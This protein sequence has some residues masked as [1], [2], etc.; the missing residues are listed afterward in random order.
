MVDF[1]M[2]AIIGWGP[3]WT[4]RGWARCGGQLLSIS[5][6]TA[7]YSLIG[8]IYGGDGRVTF[9]LPDLR[10]RA[11]IGYGQSPGTSLY[12]IGAWMGTEDRTLTQLELPSHTHIA[13]T[14]QMSVS[15]EASESV[16]GNTNVPGPNKI[17]AKAITPADGPLPKGDANIYTD[18]TN[19]D[20]TILAGAVSGRIN[21]SMTGGNQSFSILQPVSVINFVICM[22]GI[23]PSRE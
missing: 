15:I 21:N 19:A 20:T 12:R 23:F 6:F 13:H 1:L 16:E 4:P 5:Q 7:L 18:S 3:N 9:G 8:T 11:P 17:L 14:Q 2:S 22:Q 10:G